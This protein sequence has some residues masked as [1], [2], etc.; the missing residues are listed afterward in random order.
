MDKTIR[1]SLAM[2]QLEF[3]CCY[4][5][6]CSFTKIRKWVELLPPFDI[7]ESGSEEPGLFEKDD[8]QRY[9]TAEA[10]QVC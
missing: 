5:R 4:A 9:N 3:C 8:T 7:A 10:L 2:E 6:L 1:T